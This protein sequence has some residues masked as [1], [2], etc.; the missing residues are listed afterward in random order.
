M[1]PVT[2]GI[3]VEHHEGAG[4]KLKNNADRLGA[5]DCKTG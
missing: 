2:D 1:R 3:I 4:A 5:L